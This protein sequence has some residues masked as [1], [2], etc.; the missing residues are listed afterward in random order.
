MRISELDG[1][2][3]LLQEMGR[4]LSRRRLELNL[5]QEEVAREAGVSKRTVERLEAGHS[6]QLTLFLRIIRVL[7][8]L[9]RLDLLL[10]EPVTS[11][12]ELLDFRGRERKRA[13]GEREP[14]TPSAPWRWGEDA[15]KE[16]E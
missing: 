13:T 6:T 2:G 1:D 3:A 14:S 12:I 9:D 5:T 10:P 16:G 4:R 7:D 8:L 11:P 15:A